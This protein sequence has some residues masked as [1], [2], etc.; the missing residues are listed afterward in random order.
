M[1]SPQRVLST[2]YSGEPSRRGN[3]N[4]ALAVRPDVSSSSKQPISARERRPGLPLAAMILSLSPSKGGDRFSFLALGF[5]FFFSSS[6]SFLQARQ[7]P[8]PPQPPTIPYL[9]LFQLYYPPLSFFDAAHQLYLICK[10][11]VLPTYSSYIH[12][13]LSTHTSP[14]PPPPLRN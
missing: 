13:T 12:S 14:F 11:P 7:P 5:F 3:G 8:P 1:R 4:T 2:P 10:L 6:S 9:S